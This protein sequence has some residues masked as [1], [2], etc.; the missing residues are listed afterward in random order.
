MINLVKLGILTMAKSNLTTA[1]PN[2]CRILPAA[3]R[4]KGHNVK[5]LGA[6]L[7]EGPLWERKSYSMCLKNLAR[8]C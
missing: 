3:M 5:R 2:R 4:F 1:E 7:E 8:I 6:S